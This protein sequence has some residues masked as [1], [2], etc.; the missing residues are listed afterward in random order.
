MKQESMAELLMEASRFHG[1][2]RESI[3]LRNDKEK[4]AQITLSIAL[5]LERQLRD[6]LGCFVIMA[7]MICRLNKTWIDKE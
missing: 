3:A 7:E 4:G 5:E 2:L 1:D 6:A